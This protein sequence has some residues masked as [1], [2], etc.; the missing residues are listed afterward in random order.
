M[1]QKNPAGISRLFL[2]Y[3]LILYLLKK[4]GR[5]VRKCAAHTYEPPISPEL[6]KRYLIF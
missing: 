2:H 3:T 1:Q 5:G 4:G 6:L